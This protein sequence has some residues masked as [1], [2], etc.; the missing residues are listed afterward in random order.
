MAGVSSEFVPYAGEPAGVAVEVRSLQR[1]RLGHVETACIAGSFGL[2]IFRRTSR[3]AS[4]IATT[5]APLEA[6]LGVE[7]GLESTNSSISNA[8]LEFPVAVVAN[9]FC[10]AC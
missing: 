6:G 3:A 7:S 2:L 1:G 9:L 10:D 8:I 5:L 4:W